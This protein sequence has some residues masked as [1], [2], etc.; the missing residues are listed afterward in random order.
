MPKVID[1]L[2]QT[3]PDLVRAVSLPSCFTANKE[4]DTH[5]YSVISIIATFDPIW[6]IQASPSP[7]LFSGASN[8]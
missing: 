4:N 3:S 7:V 1:L 2:S 6:V 5:S 8:I